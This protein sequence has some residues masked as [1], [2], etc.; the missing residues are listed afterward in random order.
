MPNIGAVHLPFKDKDRPLGEPG[1]LTISTVASAK[2]YDAYCVLLASANEF[3]TDVKGRANFYVGGTRA[4]ERLDVFANEATGLAGE[5]RNVLLKL[6][7]PT[8]TFD[9]PA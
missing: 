8:L 3:P 4:V 6:D 1:R 5:L 9:P 7:R 2:G